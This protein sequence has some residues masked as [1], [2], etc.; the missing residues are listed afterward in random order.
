MVYAEAN[1]IYYSSDFSLLTKK[2]PKKGKIK[3]VPFRLMT[4]K[5]IRSYN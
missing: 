2:I 4:K 1:K 5:K 3:Y